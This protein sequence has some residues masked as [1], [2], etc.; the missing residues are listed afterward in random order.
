MIPILPGWILARALS[1]DVLS[2]VALGMYKVYGGVVRWAPGTPQGGQIVRHLI[3]A[4]GAPSGLP[5]TLFGMVN[6]Y[7]QGHLSDQVGNL[8]QMTRSFGLANIAQNAVLSGQIANLTKMTQQVLRISQA[9]MAL[10][11]LNL[12]VSAV[13]FAVINQKLTN[14]EK[15]LTEI[16]NDVKAIRDLLEGTERAQLRRAINELCRMDETVSEQNRH[17]I[18]HNARKT[19]AEINERYRELLSSAEVIEQAMGYEEYFCLTMLGH[20]YCTAE[21]DMAA[22][23]HK[24]LEQ[25]VHFWQAQARRIANTLLLGEDPQRYLYR[26]SVDNVPSAVLVEWLDFATEKEKGY[27]WVDDLRRKNSSWYEEKDFFGEVLEDTGEVLKGV[28]TRIKGWKFPV[29]IGSGRS[30][31]RGPEESVKSSQE[32]QQKKSSQKYDLAREQQVIIPS[33][34]KIMTRNNV[35]QGY[36]AQYQLLAENDMTPTEF[37]RRVASVP[38]EQQIDGYLILQPEQEPG[39]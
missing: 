7:Q 14:L 1:P 34:Q 6:A 23:A 8:A 37:G 4:S 39:G 38:Q 10:S 25:G 24:E 33:L 31:S 28:T 2:G 26:D 9:T 15:Q 29:P 22:L 16:Q 12:L 19:L 36:T 13:S 18:L 27:Q 35:L 21:L 3:P 32:S 17:T 20:V 11:G 5:T 30:S